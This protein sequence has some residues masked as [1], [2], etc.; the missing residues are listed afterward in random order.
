MLFKYCSCNWDP[1]LPNNSQTVGQSCS[2]TSNAEQLV[3]V[4]CA[5]GA[6]VSMYTD[7]SITQNPD[8]TTTKEKH[9]IWMSTFSWVIPDGERTGNPTEV[10][11]Y[12]EGIVFGGKS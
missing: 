9:D 7:K 5:Y 12:L 8:G 6:P 4:Q 3:C 11:N 1:Q 2:T 10:G